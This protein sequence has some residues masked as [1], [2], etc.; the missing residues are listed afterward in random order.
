MRGGVFFWPRAFTLGNYRA[1][2]NDAL[3]RA[4]TV[5]VFRTV[6]GTVSSILVTAMV[7]YALS[8]KE[9]ML[10]RFFTTVF[11]IIM[12]FSAG[13]IPYYLQVR[14]LGLMNNYLVFVLPSLFSVWN[15]I[16]MKTSFKRTIPESLIE[17][18]RIDGSGH[19]GIFFKIVLPLSIPLLAALSLFTAVGHW[20]D[21]FTGVYYVTD[22]TKQPL[23]TYLH[24]VLNSVEATNVANAARMGMTEEQRLS[25]INPSAITTTSVKMAT[26][27]FT[28]A[29]ILLIYP[30]VQRFFVKGVMIG[31]IK[32]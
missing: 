12:I 28:T 1:I 27:M 17:S 9:L 7:A 23:Q 25:M 21:W 2:F 32:E 30:F 31:S 20:N 22:R 14:N 19:A 11:F 26:I 3:Y 5:S 4:F 29:P 6:V 18:A 13:L 15:M 10:R 16:V 24:Y 8:R